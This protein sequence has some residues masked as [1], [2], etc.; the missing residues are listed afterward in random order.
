MK[1]IKPFLI[2]IAGLFAVML[3]IS[4]LMPSRVMTSR[5]VRVAGDAHA[6]LQEVRNLEG[7]K[8]WNSLLAAVTDMKVIPV[9]DTGRGGSI[10]W[11]DPRGGKN[12]MEVAGT[13]AHGILTYIT[14]GES[15]PF[16]S[17]FSIEKRHADS[18]QI[19]WYIMEDLKWYPWE[20]FYGMMAEDMK[21]PLM[22]ESLDRLKVKLEG[23]GTD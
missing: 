16:E 7:W 10:E 5:W 13:S 20:K 11:T 22:Q 3:G 14:L 2:G 19:V 21:A 12:K 18:T 1:W 15:R 4:A 8:D 9:P 6:P 23:K 17:G